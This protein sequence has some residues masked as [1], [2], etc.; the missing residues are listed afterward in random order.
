MNMGGVSVVLV[1]NAEPVLT[2][3]LAA[4]D[5]N[6]EWRREHSAPN[7]CHFIVD[8]SR[9][10]LSRPLLN[11]DEL[12]ETDFWVLGQH[13]VGGLGQNLAVFFAD[14]ESWGNGSV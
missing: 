9:F 1:D 3:V 12:L 5:D 2:M 6:V 14:L 13:L 8:G 4:V 7:T 11:V 10:E